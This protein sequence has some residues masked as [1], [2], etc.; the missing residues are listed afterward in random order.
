MEKKTERTVFWLA[1]KELKNIGRKA[2]KLN[3]T[4]SE[5]IRKIIAEEQSICNP[6]IDYAKYY[7]EL[8]KLGDDLNDELLRLNMFGDF[9]DKYCESLALKM[10]ELTKEMSKEVTEKLET[11]VVNRRDFI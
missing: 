9:D 11:E 2:K 10:I 6:K 3:L 7:G 4:R 1:D 8:K 5:Y